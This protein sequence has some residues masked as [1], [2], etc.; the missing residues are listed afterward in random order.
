MP[1]TP[2][3]WI[4]GVRGG[5]RGATCPRGSLT[6]HLLCPRQALRALEFLVEGGTALTSHTFWTELPLQPSLEQTVL[7]MGFTRAWNPQSACKSPP[8]YSGQQAMPS[9]SSAGHVTGGER[10]RGPCLTGSTKSLRPVSFLQLTKPPL[11]KPVPGVQRWGE[12]C[13]N[14]DVSCH[15]IYSSGK[16]EQHSCPTIE[17]GQQSNRSLHAGECAGCDL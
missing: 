15:N 3:L 12:R 9:L 11:E 7:D 8:G 13:L 14:K 1:G 2:L 6:D 16:L 17:N 4:L 5:L 10:H